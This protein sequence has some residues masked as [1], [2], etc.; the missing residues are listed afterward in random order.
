[1]KMTIHT[2]EPGRYWVGDISYVVSDEMYEHWL[3]EEG[4][5]DGGFKYDGKDY[6]VHETQVGDGCFSSSIEDVEF[7]VDA[8]IIGVVPLS[9]VDG[10]KMSYFNFGHVLEA[11][12]KFTF[13]FDEGTFVLHNVDGKLLE[14][15]TR[16]DSDSEEEED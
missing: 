11:H 7:P 8:G 15:F 12:D 5:Q 3:H 2:F 10:S 6:A 16:Y 1:M 9:F 13:S 14:I 4:A